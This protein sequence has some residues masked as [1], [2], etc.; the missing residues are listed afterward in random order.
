MQKIIFAVY[1]YFI[2]AVSLFMTI[3][4]YGYENENIILVCS[5]IIAAPVCFILSHFG[6][7]LSNKL[8]IRSGTKNQPNIKS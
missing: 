4:F 1:L 2:V 6:F 8:N 3:V 7:L 5:L